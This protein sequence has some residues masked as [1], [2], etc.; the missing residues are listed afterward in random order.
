M[1]N[2]ESLFNSYLNSGIFVIPQHT[3][4][5]AIGQAA[6][7]RNLDFSRISLKGVTTKEQFLKKLAR[8]LDF[9]SYF[10]MNWD[11]LSDLLTDLSWRPAGGY[12]V[13]FSSFQSLPENMAAEI[14]LIKDIFA[15]SAGYWK[16]KKVP[17]FV[18][19]S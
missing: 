15:S 6:K 4:N 7:D 18:I 17:F 1:D 16:Q 11:A 5:N 12:V 13:F 9:P 3:P 19:L 10:G 2:W 14:S 8:E